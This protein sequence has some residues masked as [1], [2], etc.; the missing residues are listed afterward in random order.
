MWKIDVSGNTFQEK[1]RKEI[2]TLHILTLVHDLH[3]RINSQQKSSLIQ[4]T[5]FGF[6]QEFWPARNNTL[7]KNPSNMKQPKYRTV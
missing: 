1:K 5:E 3:Y 7:V 4:Q 2:D 6:W